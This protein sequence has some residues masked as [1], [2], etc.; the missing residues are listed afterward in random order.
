MNRI[1]PAIIT[2]LAATAALILFAAIGG[3]LRQAIAQPPAGNWPLPLSIITGIPAEEATAISAGALILAAAL[4]AAYKFGIFRETKPHLDVTQ[5]VIIQRP[6]P[7]HQAV[8][9]NMTLHNTSKVLIRLNTAWSR[10]YQTAPLETHHVD[11][12]YQNAANRPKNDR[13]EQFAWPILDQSDKKWDKNPLKIEPNEKSHISFQFIIDRSVT[14]IQV[15]TAVLRPDQKLPANPDPDH[16]APL[17]WI[18]YT[19]LN[20]PK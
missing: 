19:A 3:A 18:C 13:Y 14:A 4:A 10:I 1:I 17:A 15:T 5:E 16:P 11:A 20:I 6:N 12:I 7:D 2:A 9:V 8:T